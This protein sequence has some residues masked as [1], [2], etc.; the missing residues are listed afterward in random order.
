MPSHHCSGSGSPTSF[1]SSHKPGVS[2]DLDQTAN[3]GTA[4]FMAPEVY[5]V[6][7]PRGAGD[8]D[9]KTTYST[10][11]DVFSGMKLRPS[12]SPRYS[13]AI[14]V[15]SLGMV[16]YFVF[17]RDLPRIEGAA[18]VP[19]Y[20]SAL[21]DGQRP[22]YGVDTPK[23]ARAIINAC[24]DTE[25]KKRPSASELVDWWFDVE[26]ASGACGFGGRGYGHCGRGARCC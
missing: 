5:T 1:R 19:A 3:C 14:D 4:R 11:I 6:D 25:P 22:V 20:F 24:W 16:Y 15:F 13:T 18:N 26:A 10:A 12:L 2:N 21:R 23:S 8:A 17:V 9:L 7:Q